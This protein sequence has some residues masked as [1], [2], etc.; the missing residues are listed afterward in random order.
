M[1][2]YL[3]ESLAVNRAHRGQ[4]NT[5]VV[6][7][8]VGMLLATVA[9]CILLPL[10]H[11]IIFSVGPMHAS[12]YVAPLVEEARSTIDTGDNEGLHY[13]VFASGR[14]AYVVLWGVDSGYTGTDQVMNLVLQPPKFA[15]SAADHGEETRQKSGDSRQ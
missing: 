2:E 15:S 12:A 10:V 13:I 3:D 14:R 1:Y 8:G 11:P 4:R 7:G 9:C 6:A 5:L